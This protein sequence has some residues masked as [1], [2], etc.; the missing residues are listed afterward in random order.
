DAAARDIRPAARRRGRETGPAPTAPGHAPSAVGRRAERYP[1]RERAA[2][3]LSERKL[4][5][6]Y[7]HSTRKARH[8]RDE[9]TA[10]LAKAAKG[11]GNGGGRALRS[12]A[13][14]RPPLPRTLAHGA[15][16]PVLFAV[17]ASLAVNPPALRA[18]RALRSIRHVLTVQSSS[19]SARRAPARRS[20]ALP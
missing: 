3:E 4:S 14:R 19:L 17:L 20:T 2:G 7:S 18:L 6:R 12:D 13:P 11:R 15:V 1:T 9:S 10:T 16:R 5:E 8:S